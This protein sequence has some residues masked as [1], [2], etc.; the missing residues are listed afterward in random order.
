MTRVESN[1]I[2]GR[3]KVVLGEVAPD[4]SVS[5]MADFGVVLAAVKDAPVQLCSHHRGASGSGG[6]EQATRPTERVEQQSSRTSMGQVG[7]KE[8][9]FGWHR[10]WAEE[11]TLLQVK[12][13]DHG[14]TIG[15]TKLTPKVHRSRRA[16]SRLFGQP[17]V[18][19]AHEGVLWV[20]QAHCA[21]EVHH[22]EQGVTFLL[23]LLHAQFVPHCFNK[24]FESAVPHRIGI[25][26]L[27]R[28]L[29]DGA[30]KLRKIVPITPQLVYRKNEHGSSSHSPGHLFRREFQDEERRIAFIQVCPSELRHV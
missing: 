14:A 7:D 25:L 3:G 17:K 24:N 2:K 8:R 23:L 20:L 21:L 9:K 10:R 18:F 4:G 30:P 1:H 19:N 13:F 15:H 26:A 12:T 28:E 29:P 16:R 11:A 27:C 6:N 5:R 22:V